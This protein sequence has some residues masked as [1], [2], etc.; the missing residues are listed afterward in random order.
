M[1]DFAYYMSIFS[2]Y[3]EKIAHT[4]S[5]VHFMAVKCIFLS[6]YKVLLYSETKHL[7]TLAAF[8]MK[9]EPTWVCLLNAHKKVHSW[10]WP[11]EWSHG[12]ELIF[13]FLIWVIDFTSP[14]I[15]LINCKLQIERKERKKTS[16]RIL[17]H[18][19]H[20]GMWIC[21][22]IFSLWHQIEHENL[23]HSNIQS[24]SIRMLWQSETLWVLN[25]K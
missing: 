16:L 11:P 13:T 24:W 1:M 8:I 3:S 12:H 4:G 15:K 10:G 21:L 23:A 2:F 25:S 7:N 5:T 9:L 17:V 20:S 14:A 6:V 19:K 18:S 22:C